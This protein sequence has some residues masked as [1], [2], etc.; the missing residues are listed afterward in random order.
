MVYQ[1]QEE[2]FKLEYESYV[3][4]NITEFKKW[5]QVS[6]GNEIYCFIKWLQSEG[7]KL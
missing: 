1:T 2:I 3:N 7:L 4:G 6:L 5:L